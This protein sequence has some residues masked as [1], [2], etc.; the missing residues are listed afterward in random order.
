MKTN[1]EWYITNGI[2]N[3][4]YVIKKTF[5]LFVH[6]TGTGQESW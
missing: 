6:V 1:Y 3:K 2:T 4:I 5:D